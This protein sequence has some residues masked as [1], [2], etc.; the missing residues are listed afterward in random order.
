MDTATLRAILG[1]FLSVAYISASQSLD[2]NTEKSIRAATFEF[3]APGARV[4]SESLV[5]SAFA[6]GANEFV[7]A[8]HL[9]CEAIGGEFGHPEL[10]D[11]DRARY[12]IG[13]IIQF[14]EQQDYIIFSLEHPP[15]VKP[16]ATRR[17]GQIAHDLYFAGWR[18]GRT[19]SIEHGS[20]SGLTRDEESGEFDWLRFS[21]PVW[22]SVGGGPVLDETGHVI[23]IAQ[24]RSRNAEANYAVPISVLPVGAPEMARIHSTAMLRALMPA[25]SSVEPFEG[26]IP[27]PMSFEKFSHELRQLRLAYFD[28]TIAPLLEATRRNFV[29]TG[30]GAAQVCN[31]LNGRSC[32]CKARAGISGTLVFDNPHADALIRRVDAGEDVSETIAGVTL[33]RTRESS[34]AGAHGHDLSSDSLLHLS[35]ALKGQAGFSLPLTASKKLVSR[36]AADPD[37]VY[38]DFRDRTWYM[39]AW[40]V[41]NRDLAMISLARKLPDGYVVLTRTVPTALSYA[42]ELQVKFVANLVYYGCEE[43][44]GEG[45]AQVARR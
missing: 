25:V 22:S 37:R 19:I 3:V 12:Q 28:R 24:A 21:G 15:A 10:M 6:I 16:L 30:A 4:D 29:V 11:S 7:T 14:S 44:P 2:S 42:A 34:V 23:G 13:D 5:G 31:L 38:V 45:I 32:K 20:F 39:G 43:L 8:A 18:S 1:C 41:G 9:F 27:L 33:F 36:A 35:L 26:E 40:P 17:D